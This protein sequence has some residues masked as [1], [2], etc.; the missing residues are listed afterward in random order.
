MARSVGRG[1]SL[2][3]REQRAPI[4]HAEHRPK[5]DC[6]DVDAIGARCLRLGPDLMQPAHLLVAGA[7]VMDF[8]DRDRDAVALPRFVEAQSRSEL[9]GERGDARSEIDS[10]RATGSQVDDGIELGGDLA[11]QDR[12]R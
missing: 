4:P 7:A 6:A 12:T 5:G 1:T 10:E 11:V 8:G 2:A 3:A 9:I